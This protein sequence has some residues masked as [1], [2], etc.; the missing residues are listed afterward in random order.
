LPGIAQATACSRRL[1]SGNL[2]RMIG[3]LERKWKYKQAWSNTLRLRIGIHRC[4]EWVGTVA[5]ALAF[6]FTVVDDTLME[7]VKLSEFSNF[8][9]S[10]SVGPSLYIKIRQALIKN[11]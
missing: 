9:S 1:Q 8:S 11:Y 10:V 2:Q 7:T 4:R 5:S 3:D 6:E